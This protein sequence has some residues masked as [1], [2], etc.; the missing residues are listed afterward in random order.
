MQQPTT[1][2]SFS[3]LLRGIT[4]TLLLLAFTQSLNSQTI[5]AISGN[6]L[7]SFKATAPSAL[8]SNVSMNGIAAGQSIQGLD[9]RPNTGQLYALGY[10]Q[11]SGEARLY[12][13]DLPTGIATS[14]GSAPVTL[15]PNM[16]KVSFDFNP[17]VD[18]I[19]VTGSNNSNY[20][21][22]PVTGAIAATDLDLA[23]AAADVNA[24]ANPSIGSVAYTNSFIGSTSTT[25]YN[26]DD[27][28]NV[29]TTQI[30]PNNGTLNT[31]G[32]SGIAVNLA[33]PSADLDIFFDAVSATN[34]AY[35]AANNGTQTTDNLYAV[36]LSTGGTTLLGPIGSGAAVSDIAV[37]I[38]RSVPA[39]L[40]G[41]L[42]YALTS[43]GNLISFDVNAPG[44]IRKLV[45][46]S[47]I[48]AGQTLAGMDFRPATGELF[49]LGYETATGLARLYTI[50][51]LTGVATAVGTTT[52]MLR[53]NMGKISMDFNP[54]VD[55]IRVTGSDNSNFRLHPVTGV[56]AATDLNLGFASGDVNAGIN[57]S[58]GAGAYT[59]SFAG[60]LTTTLYNYDDSLNVLTTQIPPNNGT[61]NTVGNS[62]I[63]VNLAD[64]SSDLDI[65]FSQYG[66]PNTAF[67]VAN[68][69][70]STFDNLYTINLAS[71][72]TTMIGKI[73]NGIAIIDIAVTIQASETACDSK[74][75]DCLKYELLTIT[76]N[77]SGDK[78]Y[79][80]RITNNCSD[81][82]VY[83]AFQLPNGVTA[84]GIGN[85]S[86]FTSLGGHVYDVRNPSFSPFYSVRFKD[87]SANGIVNGQSDLFEYTLPGF[88]NPNYI[89]VGTR[90][91]STFREAYIN[92]FGCTIG[93][94]ASRP[95]AEERDSDF[96]QAMGEF[97]VFPNPTNGDLFADLSAWEDQQVQLRAFNA[98]G[99]TLLQQSA[100]GGQTQQ[101]E[102]P[103][104][105]P[106]GL[107][108]LEMTAA[109]GEK[110][111]SKVIVKH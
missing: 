110:Q 86:T 107:Y 103:R 34:K 99:Q 29:L 15:K 83:A 23:F 63:A 10:N 14:I 73:G 33:D 81:K 58:I 100:Q 96:E 45:T 17:T 85:N 57:P 60:S 5:Y 109:N 61:L 47:G 31:I 64:P 102:M 24:T 3:S 79:R 74:T 32:T 104:N 11:T 92:V 87:Q 46:V 22:H 69:G 66:N 7:I 53:P 38:D 88:A 91:G 108:F 98:Q 49:G 39:N 71:G 4:C 95:D 78:T 6:N 37:L 44:I 68:I 27:S 25:L 62:S 111:V 93:S 76:K 2:F 97:R 50:D 8:L 106:D 48:A 21:L 75:I 90:I 26:Y 52:F 42:A 12:T 84:V 40:S 41:Q 101:I 54:T 19:R 72:A 51:V 82:L 59:N 77:T 35:L 28:L 105:L 16:G 18:R 67:L 55:R 30:P 65:L 80:I 43:N 20:R 13:L 56:V 9:F 1:R 36:N 70:T 89:H 94:S